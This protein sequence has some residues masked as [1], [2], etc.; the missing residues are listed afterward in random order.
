MV[1]AG[2]RKVI[3]IEERDGK[4]NNSFSSV[5]NEES[6]VSTGES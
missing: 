5:I 3:W 6:D 4:Q 1:A 2:M